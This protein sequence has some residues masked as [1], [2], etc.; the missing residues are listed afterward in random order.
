MALRAD[1]SKHLRHGFGGLFESHLIF[2]DGNNGQVNVELVGQAVPMELR[3]E[4]AE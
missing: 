3:R 4:G 1:R 2:A